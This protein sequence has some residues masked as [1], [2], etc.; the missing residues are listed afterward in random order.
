[1]DEIRLSCLLKYFTIP[2]TMATG[3]VIIVILE[4]SL[5]AFGA[6]RINYE[7]TLKIE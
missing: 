2:A 7:E 4:L 6:T 5:K 1:M 3:T